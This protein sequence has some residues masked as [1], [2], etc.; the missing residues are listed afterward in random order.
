MI[1]SV[2]IDISKYK[3]DIVILNSDKQLVRKSFIIKDN[4]QGYNYLASELEKSEQKYHPEKIIIGMESTGDYWKNL[5]YFLKNLSPNNSISLLNPIRTNA[6]AKTELRRAKTDPVDARDI[7]LFM[8]EKS[9]KPYESKSLIHEYIRD[10][11]GQIQ[12]L[13][14]QKTIAINA[15][16][17]ELQKV[18]PEIEK[19]F[20]NITGKQ[21]MAL[22]LSLPTAE[23]IQKASCED[24][25]SICYG[26]RNYHLQEQ[27]INRMKII[28]NNSIAFKKGF[29]AGYVVQSL[30]RLLL[31]INK[32]I[33]ILKE[34]ILEFYSK[35]SAEE[36]VL[37]SIGGIK[38]ESAIVLEAYFGDVSRFPGSK[39]IV[40]YF[41]LNPTIS[42]S[43]KSKRKSHLE[44]KGSGIIRKKLFMIIL[45]IIHNKKGPVYKYYKKLVDSG[46]PKMVAIGAS[47]RKLLTIMYAM[48][49]NNEAFNSEKL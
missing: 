11:D 42:Q 15:L 33:E 30:I 1:L 34:S 49:K 14:K 39:Q 48:L 38:K 32:E 4:Y 3:H 44:K 19:E 26:I 29:G 27:F 35:T 43:G 12:R 8:I 9:P 24:F 13:N 7:A 20:V 46:K 47:M 41:G 40:A 23:N 25:Q 22:L 31:V 5:Y 36:S 28:T 6:F 21:I 45:N 17:L 18:A 2:G 37:C 16:R 10:I